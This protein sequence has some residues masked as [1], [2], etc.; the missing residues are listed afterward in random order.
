MR[1]TP[2]QMAEFVRSICLGFGASVATA[3]KV[4]GLFVEGVVAEWERQ[5]KLAADQ[6]LQHY[7]TKTNWDVVND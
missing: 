2:H 6:E 1:P 4:A 5:D 7:S 3:Y